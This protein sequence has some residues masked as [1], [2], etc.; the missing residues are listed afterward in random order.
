M[1]LLISIYS[2]HQLLTLFF[3]SERQSR[4]IT[5]SKC[6]HLSRLTLDFFTYTFLKF[7]SITFSCVKIQ[8]QDEECRKLTTLFSVFCVKILHIHYVFLILHEVRAI[9][10][11]LP[12]VNIVS[13]HQS[14][15]VT[16]V[17]D[18]HGNLSDLIAIFQKVFNFSLKKIHF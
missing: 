2:M 15:C 14:G 8:S 17:G 3:W 12:N 13:T 16:V 7:F 4:I 6:N 11:R 5:E 1:S 18:L 10:K 9:L